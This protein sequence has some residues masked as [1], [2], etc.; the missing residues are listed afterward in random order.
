M[1][2]LMTDDLG[3][4]ALGGDLASRA[5]RALEAGCDV[6]LH[7]SGLDAWGKVLRD[8]DMVLREMSEVADVCP[9]L[10]GE[11]L[12]RAQAADAAT[13]HVKPSTRPKAG[14]GWSSCCLGRLRRL[15]RGYDGTPRS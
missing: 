5:T 7:C 3:M 6:I 12:R 11:Q 15:L 4:K 9:Q 1:A 14:R 8:P 10:S 2:C 13:A